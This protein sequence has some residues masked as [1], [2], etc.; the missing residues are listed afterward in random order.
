KL[1]NSLNLKE[2]S[3]STAPEVGRII[4]FLN[5]PSTVNF[6]FLSMHRK[7]LL[8]YRR[9]VNRCAAYGPSPKTTPSDDA[10]Q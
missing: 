9:T 7:S 6:S 10:S 1:R 4:D 5:L 3:V 8:I 2:F